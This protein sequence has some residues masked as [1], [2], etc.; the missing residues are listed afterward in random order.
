MQKT[1]QIG[2]P[3][4]G[5]PWLGHAHHILRDPLE[6]IQQQRRYGD[7]VRIRMGPK[8]LYIVNTP[9]LVR[10]L[11][12]AH[13]HQFAKGDIYDKASAVLGKGLFT[14]EGEFHR[15]QRRLVQPAFHRA[16][17]EQFA[18]IMQRVATSATRSWR[19]GETIRMDQFTMG[20]TAEIVMKTLFSEALSD[21]TLNE[22]ISLQSTLL[23][24]FL[25]RGYIPVDAYFRL[26]L[27]ENRRYA[28][29]VVDSHRIVD[30]FVAERR[31]RGSA[32]D[33]VLS[34]LMHARADDDS[35][36]MSDRQVSDETIT[37]MMA[38]TDTTAALITW[39]F[40]VLATQP[41]IARSAYEE[42]DAAFRGPEPPT[43]PILLQLAYLRRVVKEALRMYAPAWVLPRRALP[44]A[45]LGGHVI[46]AGTN[47]LYSPYALHHDE[48]LFPEPEKF[49]PQRWEPEQEKAIP[50][51]AYVP[52][53]AGVRMCIGD[54]F[55]IAEAMIVTAT[56]MH[57]WRLRH[58]TNHTIHPV[59][60][61]VLWPS[62]LQMVL[63]ERHAPS[64]PK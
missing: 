48:R 33:D 55:S 20:A 62:Q 45:E 13:Q 17:V 40:H 44:G 57:R 23:K 58:R 64:L 32:R 22:F 5:L 14:S 9:T 59:V 16:Q 53:G 11:L 39:V 1:P 28:K 27:P 19:D 37:L 52:F 47:V 61:T 26:P 15:C 46:P 7:L 8:L 54:E 49:L 38:G 56:V 50:R 30:G 21:D 42:V 36:T 35:R 41:T 4:G 24:G 10:E 12:T 3:T 18:A 63:E 6:F 34:L 29:A 31:T 51:F 60:S 43:I 2:S 25:K